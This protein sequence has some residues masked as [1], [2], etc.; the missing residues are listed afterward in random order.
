M[1]WW[2]I[3][4]DWFV[5]HQELYLSQM[6]CLGRSVRFQAVLA[7]REH[8]FNLHS[9]FTGNLEIGELCLAYQSD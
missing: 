7:M 8:Q 3:L 9:E 6:Q 5:G 1:G 4:A 2:V